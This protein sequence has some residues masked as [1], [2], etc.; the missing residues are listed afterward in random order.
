MDIKKLIF[1]LCSAS[2]VSGSEES[3]VDV[4]KEHLAGFSEVT[5]DHNGNLYAV[6]GNKNADK[7]ILLD[8]HIDRIGLIVTDID[9]N[10]F[11]KVDKCGG[12]D[13]R[14]LQ[15]TVLKAE[16]GL[17][18]TVCCLPPH[19]T[20]GSES[21]ANP[22]A[23][24]WVDFGMPCEEVKKQIKIGD[25]LTFNYSPQSLLGDKITSPALDNRCGAAALIYAADLLKDKEL[26]YKI[27]I[28][29]SSQEETYGTGAITGAYKIEAEEAISVDVS[30]A[31]QPD[32]SGQYASIELQK[33]AMI[34]IA[35][36]LNKAMTNKLI[37]LA[38]DKDIPYQLEPL[39]SSTGTNADHISVSKSG[40]KTALI[41]IPQRYMHTQAEVISVSGVESVSK[42]ICEYILCG[43]AFDD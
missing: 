32:I 17:C 15:D 35:P 9:K 41:S 25:K 5:T 24:T 21:K 2:G 37:S 23:K 4:A 19:L 7:T 38:K 36:V 34:G 28:L 6:T 27:V 10:G 42:L 26:E 39:S 13:A 14:V 22:I 3:A 31:S 12:I 20:D 18:G 43:G 29:L 30:F 16:N 40:V 11:V 33:G 8:A 1:D